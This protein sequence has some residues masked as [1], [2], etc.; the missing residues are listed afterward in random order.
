ME[1]GGQAIA[2][3]T[4]HMFPVFR[5]LTIAKIPGKEMAGI[6]G[7]AP[8]TY[9]KWRTGKSK[10]PAPTL[11]FLTLLLANRIEELLAVSDEAGLNGLRLKVTVKSI[12]RHL[13]DQETI[14]NTLHPGAVR[15]GARL[16]RQWWQQ[17]GP[18]AER[19]VGPEPFD[20]L[21][22]AMRYPQLERLDAAL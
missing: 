13:R 19:D 5:G 7:V 17:N 11:V 22:H 12:H 10:V 21:F 6:V 18:E 1:N 3:G 4:G 9:S 8:P 14:N 16:F 20:A 2:E 15:L